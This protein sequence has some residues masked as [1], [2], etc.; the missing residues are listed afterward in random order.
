[1]IEHRRDHKFKPKPGQKVPRCEI[2]GRGKG[3]VAH[4]GTPKSLNVF[5]SS[6][7]EFVY[8]NAK[9]MWQD[10]ITE[11]LREQGVEPFERVVVEGEV[12]FP[13]RQ[14]R[15]QGNYRFILEKALGDALTKGGW[16]EDDD[17]S[18][19]EFGNLAYHYAKGECWTKLILFPAVHHDLT[20]PPEPRAKPAPQEQA[21]FTPAA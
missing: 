19:Y 15:D 20:D 4:V 8:L 2:C 11:L 1:M 21:L 7:S 10:R 16:L 18:R 3:N 9:Q 12:C 17:W 14:R 5:A 13:D 6:R